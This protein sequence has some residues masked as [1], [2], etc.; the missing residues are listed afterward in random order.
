MC[1][2]LPTAR[3]PRLSGKATTANKFGF[4][5]EPIADGTNFRKL[6]GLS[7][8]ALAAAN[9]STACGARCARVDDFDL[10]D[11]K[12]I[13]TKSNTSPFRGRR[14]IVRLRSVVFIR[15]S[16]RAHRQMEPFIASLPQ[17]NNQGHAHYFFERTPRISDVL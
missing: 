2:S 16:F 11:T 13:T 9:G 15:C 1:P 8:D 3:N 17:Q 4:A 10:Q 5:T 6:S 7:V 14:E 12:A